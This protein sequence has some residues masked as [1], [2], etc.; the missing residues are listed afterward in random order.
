MKPVTNP[1]KKLTEI[2]KL[3]GKPYMIRE[4]DNEPV[5]YRKFEHYELEVSGLNTKGDKINAVIF[6]WATTG[7]YRRVETIEGLSS[8]HSVTEALRSTSQKYLHSHPLP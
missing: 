2:L 4:I 8:I 7:G 5:I 6:V 1:G 3:L